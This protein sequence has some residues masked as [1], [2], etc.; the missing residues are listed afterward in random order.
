M[1]EFLLDPVGEESSFFARITELGER[2]PGNVSDRL[3]MI[4]G[5]LASESRGE[6]E[7]DSEATAGVT[8][9]SLP[10]ATQI[11]GDLTNNS[12][13]VLKPISRVHL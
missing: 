12:L 8:E 4:I 2:G 11:Q 1:L 3:A 13:S 10:E 6:I 9:A 7:R 5:G